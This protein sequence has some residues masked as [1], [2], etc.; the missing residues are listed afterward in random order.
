MSNNVMAFTNVSDMLQEMQR[1][2]E[3]ADRLVVPWQ[4]AVKP[5]SKIIRVADAFGDNRLILIYGQIIDIVAE[6]EK[7][8]NLNNPIEAAEFSYT[9]KRYGADWYRSFRYGRFYSHICPEGEY[10]EIHLAAITAVIS[11]DE[12]EKARIQGWPQ[13]QALIVHAVH[14]RSLS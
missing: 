14:R 13:S 1:N 4:R 11:D 6:E 3:T 5:G 7:Y 9:E 12:F 10:G 2:R 8:Y